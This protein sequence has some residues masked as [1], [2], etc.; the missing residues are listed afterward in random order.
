MPRSLDRSASTP[1]GRRRV[2]SAR[3]SSAGTLGQLPDRSPLAAHPHATCEPRQGQYVKWLARKG[4]IHVNRTERQN[5]RGRHPAGW[6][7]HTP[8]KMFQSLHV[9]PLASERSASDFQLSAGTTAAAGL[10]TQMGVLKRTVRRPALGTSSVS[11][12]SVV[13]DS[14]QPPAQ[15]C[16][17]LRGGVL[18]QLFSLACLCNKRCAI[19]Q[20]SATTRRRH[21]ARP[22]TQSR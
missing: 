12:Q 3:K 4:T 19:S 9:S 14:W 1:R 13:A 15:V 18:G 6:V 22:Y 10:F 7:A 21:L 20:Q 2:S 5:P 17:L 16:R 11:A 8:L